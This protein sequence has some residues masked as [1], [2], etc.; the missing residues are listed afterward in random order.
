MHK[1]ILLFF[2]FFFIFSLT[3]VSAFAYQKNISNSFAK[4]EGV[5]LYLTALRYDPYPAEPG[6]YI[7]LWLKVENKGSIDAKDITIT[8]TPRYPFS[9]NNGENPKT[10]FGKIMSHQ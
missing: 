1:K 2:I 5:A 7:E 8:L 10:S 4:D 6:H 9:L 3:L